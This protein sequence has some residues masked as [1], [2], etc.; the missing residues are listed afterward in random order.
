MEYYIK[1]TEKPDGPYDMMSIIRK[2]RNGSLQEE[3]LIATTVF[4]E[5]RPA[6]LYKEFADLFREEKTVESAPASALRGQRGLVSLLQSGLDF[7]KNNSFASIYSGIFIFIWLVISLLFIFH[8]GIVTAII[9]IA[10]SYFI[11]G[12]Y[13]YG[14]MRYLR[15]NPVTIGLIISRMVKTAVPMGVVSLVVSMIMLPGVF[16]LMTLIS[17]DIPYVGLPIVFMLLL[18]VLTLLAF[19]PLLIVEKEQDFW[20]A[21]R[22]SVQVVTMHK[23]QNLGVVFGLVSLNFLLFMLMPVVLP[24]TMAALAELYEEKFVY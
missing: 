7:L 21:M 4:E 22:N 1:N 6:A 9:G 5:P 8:G 11:I 24:I 19:T 13:L 18:C 16:L 2:I 23:G 15:G 12:G 3:T 10:A 14:I 17:M 20:D